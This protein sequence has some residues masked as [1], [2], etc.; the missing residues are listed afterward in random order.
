LRILFRTASRNCVHVQDVGLAEA[1]DDAVW[2]YAVE[3][4]LVIV[5]KDADFRQRSFLEGHPPRIIWIALGNCSTAAI[6]NLLRSRQENI[7]A[8]LS[9]EQSS[10][11]SL[12]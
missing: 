9:D 8:F 2:N 11:L 4:D 10:F 5:K 12:S 6:E 1:A 7:Q 3:R